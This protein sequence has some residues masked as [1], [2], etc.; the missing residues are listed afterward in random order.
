MLPI[1]G[2]QLFSYHQTYSIPERCKQPCQLD[3]VLLDW[4]Q[5]KLVSSSIARQCLHAQLA[6]L[7]RAAQVRP[8]SGSREM[9]PMRCTHACQCL[10]AQAFTAMTFYT[11]QP[12]FDGKSYF[13]ITFDRKNVF[14][15]FRKFQSFRAQRGAKF[16]DFRRKSCVFR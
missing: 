16:F 12:N 3:L 2:A 4:Y 6:P 7:G 1:A 13:F 5:H 15:D 14:N 10:C 11:L 8:R 9:K